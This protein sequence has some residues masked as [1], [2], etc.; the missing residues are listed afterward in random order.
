MF[1]FETQKPGIKASFT[2]TVLSCLL[3]SG[4][5]IFYGAS[6][7]GAYA[8]D[9]WDTWTGWNDDYG[10]HELKA[11]GLY[12]RLT[13]RQDDTRNEPSDGYSPGLIL[14]RAITGSSWRVDLQADFKIPPGQVKRFSYGVWLGGDST[15]PSLGSASAVLKLLAQRQNGPGPDDDALIITCLPGGAPVK[16]PKTA[17]TLRFERNGNLF[18]VSYSLNKKEFKPVARLEAAAEDVPAQEFFIGGFAAGD[19]Q[20]AYARFTSLKMNGQETLQ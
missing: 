6:H 1:A 20:G 19:T 3:L 2:L 10:S 14:S 15:R 5:A 11:D 4:C 18:T 13:E 17:E 7:K 8:I 16:I 12:Y 9:D